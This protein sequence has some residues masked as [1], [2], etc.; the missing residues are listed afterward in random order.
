MNMPTSAAPVGTNLSSG[1]ERQHV[2][3]TQFRA[4][5]GFF[6]I[7]G[8]QNL[9]NEC[10]LQSILYNARKRLPSAEI[11]SVSYEP[12]DTSARHSVP[13]VPIS[14]R[15]FSSRVNGKIIK[16]KGGLY[17][18]ARIVFQRLPEELLDWVQAIKTLR[19]TDLL[20]MTGTGML[21]DY[22]TSTFG[23]PYDVLKWSVAARLAGC[24]LRFVGVG[25]GPIY[26][27]LSRLFIRIALSL[28][29]WRSF[30]DEFSK[31]RIAKTGFDSSNDAVFPDLAFSLPISSLSENLVSPHN[32][33]VVGLGIMDHRDIYIETQ[34]QHEA[35]YAAYLDKMCNFVRW[36][37]ENGYLIRILQG[38]V[39]YDSISRADFK[40]RLEQRGIRYDE[41]GIFDQGS[42]SVEELISQIA[43]VDL[44][45]SPRFHSLILGLMLGKPGVSISYDPKNDVLLEGVGLGKYCQSITELDADKLIAQFVDLVERKEE[46]RPLIMLRVEEYRK[47]LEIEYSLIFGDIRD[48]SNCDL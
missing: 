17:R 11:Y 25:V 31:N 20:V 34:E 24:K 39:N 37:T 46:V 26:K 35:S 5:V 4:K 15:Y 14:S 28:A 29:D 1:D 48:K 12:E 43:K 45:V 42:L 44:V 22:A 38:D 23:Y 2:R 27:A 41:C 32:K 7:F 16:R 3:E 19:G 36:L 6:G 21:T 30:R 13:A 18:L 47:L 10:T 8:I 33:L 40:Q 9:G